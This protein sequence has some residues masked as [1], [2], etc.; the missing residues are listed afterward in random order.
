MAVLWRHFKAYVIVRQHYLVSADDANYWADLTRAAEQRQTNRKV[1]KMLAEVRNEV[2]VQRAAAEQ[3]ARAKAA[4]EAQALE[5]GSVPLA[6]AYAAGGSGSG[7][8]SGNAGSSS[9]TFNPRAS[10]AGSNAAGSDAAAAAAAAAAGAFNP[11]SSVVDSVLRQVTALFSL[12][13]NNSNAAGAGG[14]G[15]RGGGGGSLGSS[16]PAVGGALASPA[17]GSDAAAPPLP[18]T[19]TRGHSMRTGSLL[20]PG[21]LAGALG[22]QQ[23]QPGVGV[24][25]LPPAGRLVTSPPGHQPLP[26]GG[27]AR[28]R[29]PPGVPANTP[30]RAGPLGLPPWR[31]TSATGALQQQLQQ[32]Q[33][34]QPPPPSAAV[35]AAA[36]PAASLPPPASAADPISAAALLST[37]PYSA[38]RHLLMHTITERGESTSGALLNSSQGGGE[39]TSSKPGAAAIEAAAAASAAAAAGAASAASQPPPPV[40]SSSPPMSD[41]F[42]NPLVAVAAALQPPVASGDSPPSPRARSGTARLL[43]PGVRDSSAA[44]EDEEAGGG[45]ARSVLGRSSASSSLQLPRAPLFA[46]AEERAALA[47][48]GGDS[49]V[50]RRTAST[51]SSSGDV[52]APAPGPSADA[53]SAAAFIT[54]PARSNTPPAGLTSSPPMLDDAAGGDGKKK[55]RAEAAGGKAAQQKQHDALASDRR[56]AHNWWQPLPPDVLPKPSS[57]LSGGGG[58][59][60]QDADAATDAA[61]YAAAL[62][63]AAAAAAALAKPSVRQRKTINTMAGDR[64]VSVN[65]QHYAVLVTDVDQP[66]FPDPDVDGVGG[67]GAGWW[68]W[69]RWGASAGRGGNGAAAAAEAGSSG[70]A[71][72][73]TAD[74]LF[75]K[76]S[77]AVGRSGALCFGGFPVYEAVQMSR[78]TLAPVGSGGVGCGAGGSGVGVGAG[79]GAGYS[80]G[81]PHVSPGREMSYGYASG[82]GLVGRPRIAA[83]QHEALLLGQG[84]GGVGGGGGGGGSGG[85]RNLPPQRPPLADTP[86]PQP[87]RNLAAP[88]ATAAAAAT[89]VA[90]AAATTAAQQQQPIAAAAPPPPAPA[91]FARP[92]PNARSSV[93]CLPLPPA[94]TPAGVSGGGRP[95]PVWLQYP[96]GSAGLLPPHPHPR[97]RRATAD[98]AVH[99]P[100]WAHPSSR[101]AVGASFERPPSPSGGGGAPGLVRVVG[102]ATAQGR[103][104]LHRSSMHQHQHHHHGGS[105]LA[106]WGV[107]EADGSAAAVAAAAARYLGGA[108]GPGGAALAAAE[109]GP[110]DA[111]IA[112]TARELE[113]ARRQLEGLLASAQQQEQQQQQQQQQ[114]PVNLAGSIIGGLLGAG[115]GAAAGGGGE[116]R[117]GAD[118]GGGGGNSGVMTPE[119]LMRRLKQLQ[120][121]EARLARL[122]ELRD[123]QCMLSRE[124]SAAAPLQGPFA[125][126]GALDEGAAAAAAMLGAPGVAPADVGAPSH[127]PPPAPT[128]GPIMSAFAAAAAAGPPTAA[129]ASASLSLLGGGGGGGGMAGAVDRSYDASAMAVARSVGSAAA[130][131]RPQS[132]ASVALA[133]G[134]G[135]GALSRSASMRVG[136][137]GGPGAPPWPAPI[138][139]GDSAVG[140]ATVGMPDGHFAYAQSFHAHNLPPPSAAPTPTAAHLFHHQQ[141]ALLNRSPSLVAGGGAAAAAAAMQAHLPP[142]APV[143]TPRG[144]G[145]YNAALRQQQALRALAD[146]ASPRGGGAYSGASDAVAGASVGA[147]GGLPPVPPPLRSPRGVGGG[148]P[149]I[150]ASTSSSALSPRQRMAA[151]A[152][153]T[154]AAGGRPLAVPSAEPPSVAGASPTPSSRAGDGAGGGAAGNMGGP[155]PSNV[156]P[157]VPDRAVERAAARAAAA[158]AAAASGVAASHRY[159]RTAGGVSSSATSSGSGGQDPGASSATA[160]AAAAPGPP[161][162]PPAAPLPG[163]LNLAATVSLGGGIAGG[164]PNP[165]FRGFGPPP[166][167]PGPSAAAAAANAPAAP[168]PPAAGLR[169]TAST[170]S[171][172]APP[173]PPLTVPS[174]RSST[175]GG[176]GPSDGGSGGG[177]GGQAAGAAP[178]AASSSQPPTRPP[179]GGSTPPSL[180]VAAAPQHPRRSSSAAGDHHPSGHAQRYGGRRSTRSSGGGGSGAPSSTIEIAATIGSNG[181]TASALAQTLV[182]PAVA[183][184]FEDDDGKQLEPFAPT[185]ADDPN[186]ALPPPPTRPRGWALVRAALVS[187]RLLSLP[188]DPL[189]YSVVTSTFRRL[190]PLD[191]QGAVPVVDYSRVD[192]LLMRWEGAVARLQRLQY[193][194]DRLMKP[195]APASSKEHGA[196]RKGG[197]WRRWWPGRDGARRRG[198][199]LNGSGGGRPSD[200]NDADPEHQDGADSPPL[201]ALPVPM[202]RLP[203]RWFPCGLGAAADPGGRGGVG[204]CA[205]GLAAAATC[206][207]GPQIPAIPAVEREIAQ[208]ELDIKA[209][210]KRAWSARH[211]RSWFVFFRSQ[212]A[213]TVATSTVVHGEDDRPFRVHP[214]PGPEEVNWPHLWMGWRERDLRTWLTWPL[215]V[216]IVVFPITFITSVVARLEYLLCPVAVIKGDG[217]ASALGSGGDG[218]IGPDSRPLLYWAWYC[219]SRDDASSPANFLKS[220]LNGWVP[221]LLLNAWLVMAMPRLVYALVQTEGGCVSL[222]ALERRI[223]GV[224][225]Y[226]DVLNVFLQG[227]IG[228]SFFQQVW[229]IVFNPTDL[230]RLLGY[231]LPDS[232]NFFMQ[233]IAMRAFFLVWLR[234]CIPHGGVWQNWARK[235][236]CPRSCVAQ[237]NTE[238]DESVVYGSRTPR[239]GFEMGHVLLMYLIAL[240][241]SVV[242]PLL[243]PFAV[244]W[245]AFAWVAWR[246]NLAYV[247]TR[248][249]ESGGLMWTFLFD[250]LCVCLALFQLFTFCVLL[251][252]AAYVQAFLIAI[253]L[254]AATLRFYRSARQRFSQ[255]IL[256]QPLDFC[257]RAPDATVPV[258]TYIPPPLQHRS[259]GWY[260]EHAKIWAGWGMPRSGIV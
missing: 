43:G 62:A 215:L 59:E 7:G 129:N 71:V 234:L 195:V 156:S 81:S 76:L 191:Y 246:H 130:L 224:F 158:A 167:P 229:R 230:P 222:S 260:P 35:V 253:T 225:F 72:Q 211:A 57:L 52:G 84:S 201:P 67:D 32:Q 153:A 17:A 237:C 174:S 209:E 137:G 44:D 173:P 217:E 96:P 74:L 29:S 181:A 113:G 223:G 80:G 150:A 51:T 63:A 109:Q 108:G 75:R 189:G 41:A 36:A 38:A 203:P 168:V 56:V 212:A 132:R 188:D 232:S 106:S 24:G 172:R 176:A 98:S 15:G 210:R 31:R 197:W 185:A 136:G 34:R 82:G 101:G 244:A 245:F 243:V 105:A 61:A 53:P 123:R 1:R 115:G 94:V 88:S 160:A 5:A 127:P 22:Q 3:A 37:S 196:P 93:D 83:L 70:N 139:A 184:R 50:Q 152:A 204:G 256:T 120:K 79:A 25:E 138:V 200:S 192:A 89:R 21:A 125:A 148:G 179:T 11:R 183:P 214:A 33:Q 194:R 247:Y 86:Q 252:K 154:A 257:L 19:L 227:V 111:E 149:L 116:G 186:A 6:S 146:L 64:H 159:S 118:G 206:W 157:V 163:A 187:G 2:A 90:P 147:G 69:G 4:R 42:P 219:R 117:G 49:C 128:P 140:G 78:P 121:A 14:S 236:L 193:V 39:G 170:L 26:A 23:E 155:L 9:G 216:L 65:A 198:G 114:K 233:F 190:F 142:A 145:P 143:P 102:A 91:A 248:K 133:G 199:L 131:Q 119:D 60:P 112:Q 161:P 13:G 16:W 165:S 240:S 258:S 202:A 100:P 55:G 239:Y 235:V 54:I 104:S 226:W 231:A 122:A 171:L 103:E 249:Y 164:S 40:W 221:A 107:D 151:A 218:G 169:Q 20:G 58:A 177:Q 162:P 27:S 85:G 110:S 241:F 47:A 99:L 182:P 18:L 126:A 254:P 228:A 259:W 166:P 68:G 8:G 238:R 30:S 220:L 141:H 92:P 73:G 175:R 178:A 242:S 135:G 10:L 77:E 48:A 180:A 95:L 124:A 45:G 251:F 205:V 12:S 208:L 255:G 250:R 134:G 97:P 46:S 28:M 87:E 213:A 207:T 66:L 144:A